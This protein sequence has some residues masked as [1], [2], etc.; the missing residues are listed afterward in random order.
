MRYLWIAAS[1]STA[2][3]PSSQRLLSVRGEGNRRRERPGA[4]GEGLCSI[5]WLILD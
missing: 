3:T 1:V 2:Q 5:K 4:V